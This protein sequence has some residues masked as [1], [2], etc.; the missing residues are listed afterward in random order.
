M[1]MQ[2]DISE[3][4]NISDKYVT[5]IIY[6]CLPTTSNKHYNSLS[7]FSYYSLIKVIEILLIL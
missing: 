2:I 6:S 4:K 5:H 3:N 7:G 1:K